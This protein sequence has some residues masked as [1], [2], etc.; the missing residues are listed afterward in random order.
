VTAVAR[1][2]PPSEPLVYDG[3]MRDDLP[4]ASYPITLEAGQVLSVSAVATSGDLDSYLTLADP[5][6]AVVAENDDI[7]ATTLDAAIGYTA[8]VAGDY[9]VTVTNVAG[10]AGTY[11]LTIG[12]GS[13]AEPA[14]ELTGPVEYVGSVGGDV[15]EALYPVSLQAGQAILVT[16]VAVSGD[17]DPLIAIANSAGVV[18]AQDNAAREPAGAD[19]ELAF[20]SPTNDSYTI[21]VRAWEQTSGDYRVTVLPVDPSE[22]A[23]VGRVHL[24]GPALAFDSTNFRIH[25]TIGGADA[26]TEEYVELVAATMEEVLQIQ[27]GLGW[28]APPPDGLMGGDDRYDVYLLDVLTSDDES[29]YGE[30]TPEWPGRD[31][32]NSDAVEERAAPGFLVLDNDFAADEI[33]PGRDPVA[34][35]RATAAHEFH[36]VIQFGFDYR[37]PM[38]WYFEST[39]AWMETVTYPADQDATG[40]ASSLF[41]YSELC[42]G[43]AGDADPSGDQIYGAWLFLQSL[44]DVYGNQLVTELWG[45]VAVADGWDAIDSVLE[46]YGDTRV[47]AVR[48][49]RLQNLVRDY[50]W[51]PELG[52]ATVWRD[53]TID[54]E[55]ARS[56]SGEGV[57]PLGANYFSVNVL[58]GT[59][60]IAVDDPALELWLVGISGPTATV[61]AAGADRPVSVSGYD[62]VYLMVFDPT[63]DYD[64]EACSYTTY[65]LTVTRVE[66]AGAS[67]GPEPD[68]TLDATQFAPLGN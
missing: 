37:E 60:Q 65:G 58:P 33:D 6:G 48:R 62:F 50:A 44:V 40:Y 9:V 28:P 54:A 4:A 67:A 68:F 51:T 56:H 43:L 45:A 17:L 42:L 18:V 35:L 2:L 39:A 21:V 53:S 57:Q 15:P 64:V 13:A 22:I 55:G 29:R 46:S 3:E 8:E 16:A 5:S 25:Y 52:D 23:T 66:D 10:T 36:H 49:F 59:Y 41:E 38:S 47:D 31:N 27:T 1:A 32:P 14:P 26:A 34:Q 19:A 30:A 24:S 11:T 61:F 7:D 20:V 63:A 12:V